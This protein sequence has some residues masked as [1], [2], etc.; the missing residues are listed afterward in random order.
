LSSWLAHASVDWPHL[1]PGA[2]GVAL[3]AAA[4]L[5]TE[6]GAE[7]EADGHSQRRSAPSIA[8][9]ALVSV[10]IVVAALTVGRAVLSVHYLDQGKAVLGANP[11]QAIRKA[12]DSLAFNGDSLQALYLKSAGYAR[13]AD[14]RRSRAALLNATRLEPRNFLPWALLGDLA[15]RRG[16]LGEARR[17]YARAWH[18]NPQALYLRDL[19]RNPAP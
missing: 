14:Y 15:A 4:F 16:V 17:A 8:V 5:V 13:L 10:G 12:N 11:V 19:S 2:T 9:R 3:L 7:E 6:P 1:L 18:L